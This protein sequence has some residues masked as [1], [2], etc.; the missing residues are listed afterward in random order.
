MIFPAEDLDHPELGVV[1]PWSGQGF[2]FLGDVE[3]GVT[4]PTGEA[5]GH[6]VIAAGVRSEGSNGSNMDEVE[7][8]FWCRRSQGTDQRRGI[9]DDGD[10]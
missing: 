3:G 8:P 7:R 4:D 6:T 10:P 5:A 2:G 9:D 1:S